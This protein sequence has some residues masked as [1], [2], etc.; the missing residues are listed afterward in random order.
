MAD[1]MLV[2]KTDNYNKN[3]FKVTIKGDYN[4][5]DYSTREQYFS[6][7]NF[8]EHVLAELKNLEENFSGYHELEDF[9]SEWLWLPS[10]SDMP[11][12]TLEDLTVEYIDDNGE[13]WDVIL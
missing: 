7:E 4:D 9:D 8:D 11:C 3:K 10:G 1:Y 5:A 12:H 13:I 6:K 2:K